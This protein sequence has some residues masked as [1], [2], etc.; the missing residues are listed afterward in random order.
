[1]AKS[2]WLEH[3]SLEHVRKLVQAYP[4]IQKLQTSEAGF[5]LMNVTL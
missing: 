2:L 4:S 5:F 3:T 1:M